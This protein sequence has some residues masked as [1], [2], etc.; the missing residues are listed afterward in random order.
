[1]Q[2]RMPTILLAPE[3]NLLFL[4]QHCSFCIVNLTVQLVIT[5]DTRK[6]NLLNWLKVLVLRLR[7]VSTLTPSVLYHGLFS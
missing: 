2:L 7:P 4:F 5:D 6:A 3:E 1:M